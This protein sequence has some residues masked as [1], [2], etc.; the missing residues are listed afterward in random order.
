MHRNR[1]RASFCTLK[2]A[3]RKTTISV[4][5]SA[6]IWW[7]L[8][9]ISVTKSTTVQFTSLLLQTLFLDCENL[10][11]KIGTPE[12]SSVNPS[13][14]YINRLSVSIPQQ[15]TWVLLE[16]SSNNNALWQ[17]RFIRC[18]LL[19]ECECQF[20]YPRNSRSFTVPTGNTDG[21]CSQVMLLLDTNI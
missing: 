9:T 10:T 1:S 6:N 5:K 8:F 14:N 16:A 19:G 4:R 11:D 20:W 21:L 7:E 15:G 12:S 13:S 2:L 17:V 18:I 3:N